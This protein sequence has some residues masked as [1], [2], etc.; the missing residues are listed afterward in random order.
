MQK[1]YF[2]ENARFDIQNK[3][4]HGL[5]PN[6]TKF[7]KETIIELSSHFVCFTLYNLLQTIIIFIK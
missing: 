3:W 1:P 4:L 5:S 2:V 7:V 6:I